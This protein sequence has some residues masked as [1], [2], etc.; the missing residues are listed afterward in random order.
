YPEN[1]KSTIKAAISQFEL[2]TCVKFVE[3]TSENDY[4]SIENSNGDVATSSSDRC[5]SVL[6]KVGGKQSLS[7]NKNGCMTSGTIQHE[8]MHAL[9]FYHEQ[10]RSDRDDF[11]K[12]IWFYI[13][14]AGCSPVSALP[15][16]RSFL[17]VAAGRD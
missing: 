1:E 13:N 14:V 12:I 5:W 9:G 11:V 3:K 17:H 7:L 2:L 15:A 8:T 4:I 10:S 6:G 16:D